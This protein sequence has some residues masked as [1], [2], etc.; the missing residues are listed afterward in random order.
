MSFANRR[1]AATGQSVQTF[2]PGDRAPGSKGQ[3]VHSRCRAPTALTGSKRCRFFTCES[4]N[5]QHRT[6]Y[7]RIVSRYSVNLKMK[8]PP[9]KSLGQSVLFIGDF[10]SQILFWLVLQPDN[11]DSRPSKCSC[12]PHRARCHQGRRRRA[13]HFGGATES[14]IQGQATGKSGQQLGKRCQT[15]HEP[16]AP[17]AP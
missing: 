6:S 4:L 9:V 3:K 7:R 12:L 17:S 2:V 13:S 8:Y 10:I 16:F 15:P 1:A 5:W 14:S 11:I